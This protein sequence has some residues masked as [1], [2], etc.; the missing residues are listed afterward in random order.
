MGSISKGVS[1]FLLIIL[2]VSSLMIVES[3]TVQSIIKPSVPEFTVRIVD[4]SYDVPAS[5]TTTIDPYNNKTITR[6]FPATHVQNISVDLIVV[7]Q[8]FPETIDGNTSFL[9]Y[10][11]R[12]KPHFGENWSQ[13]FNESIQIGQTGRLT[14][15]SNSQYTVLF[16]TPVDDYSVGDQV[17]YQVKAIL[18]YQYTT[19]EYLEHLDPWYHGP[20]PVPVNHT[21][22]VE[23]SD[24]SPTQTFIVPNISPTPTPFQQNL[25]L[26]LP[27]AVV[28]LAVVLVF[29]FLLFRRHRKTA[30]VNQ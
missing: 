28:V 13:Q 11:L 24:W 20:Y 26:I 4:H 7:N 25:V 23:S 14:P 21:V 29:S 12:T 10:N 3:A 17:D 22:Y 18:A 5:V 27:I 6:T 30:K 8:P 16:S 19:Y 9:Y 2:A 15:Q 1:F